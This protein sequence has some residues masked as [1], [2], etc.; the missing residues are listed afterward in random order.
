[1]QH[2]ASLKN[3]YPKYNPKY[4]EAF[5]DLPDLTQI[6]NFSPEQANAAPLSQPTASTPS[7]PQLTPILQKTKERYKSATLP[8]QNP[9]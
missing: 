5:K 1:M 4:D 2:R 7:A 6:S 9:Y 3:A 8:I